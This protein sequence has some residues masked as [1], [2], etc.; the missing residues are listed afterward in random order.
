MDA[1]RPPTPSQLRRLVEE[2]AE[3]GLDLDGSAA[4][5][6][7]A[8]EEIAYAMRPKV[9]ERYV[10]SYGAIIQ[11]ST[12]PDTWRAVTGLVIERGPIALHPDARLR[13]YADGIAS[14]LMRHADGTNEWITLD[15]PAG[16]ERD[17][18]VLATALGATIV[19]RHP[20]GLVRIVGTDGVYRWRGMGWRY[21]PL[22]DQW[23]DQVADG[24][25]DHHVL[26]RLLE[27]AVHDLGARGIGAILVYRPDESLTLSHE[28][29]LQT[30]PKLRITWPM[31]LA[32]L[33]HAL[34]QSDGAALFDDEGVLMEIGVRLV[35]TFE[36]EV[37][38]DGYRGM[39]HT[40]ARRYS[41]D[42]PGATV[43]VVSEDGPVTVFR[44]GQLTGTA[45]VGIDEQAA[46]S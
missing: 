30:P 8:I 7:L 14:W 15:R 2:L 6:E 41:Y 9:H 43:I 32:P 29:R 12:D 11:P 3:A 16:S 10:P 45:D 25:G 39:R 20:T 28:L 1:W 5:H 40:A 35:P 42:D 38:V 17:L 4:W 36:A 46:P 34:A 23:I 18:V 44:G 13:S 26:H 24:D 22:V 27:F 33:R 31:A 37:G 19:Q 21:E